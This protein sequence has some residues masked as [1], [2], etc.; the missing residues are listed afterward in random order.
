MLERDF[1]RQVEELLNLYKWRW[2]HFR[3]A[4]VKGKGKDGWVTPLSGY[5]GFPDYVAV[6]M[7]EPTRL[8]F[9]ELKSEKGRVTEEQMKWFVSLVASG[10]ESYIWKPSDWNEIL[11][12]L[13]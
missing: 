2:C 11:D 13:K 6:R 4:R 8:L 7:G 1:A 12:T 9:I 3:P 5:S 10:N